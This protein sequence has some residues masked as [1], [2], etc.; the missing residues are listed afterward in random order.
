M[1]NK[2]VLLDHFIIPMR[3]EEK[4]KGTKNDFHQ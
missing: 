2:S 1:L 3:E 4:T